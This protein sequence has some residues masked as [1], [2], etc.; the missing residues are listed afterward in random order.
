MWTTLLA[1]HDVQRHRTSKRELDEIRAVIEPHLGDAQIAGL[2]ADGR[3]PPP[4]NASLQTASMA[5]ACAGYRV[6]A[7]AGHHRVTIDAITL[8]VGHSGQRYAER[9]NE[10]SRF[11]PSIAPTDAGRAVR[12][13]G[14]LLFRF[15]LRIG[16]VLV[17]AC[18]V[19]R[20][21]FF[22]GFLQRAE[23]L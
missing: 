7:K 8:A 17:G 23:G 22:I 11:V 6:T 18:S 5:I 9:P 2:S 10:S 16:L 4:Y 14:L 3:S 15:F 12:S 19:S 13:S 21:F 20:G 1:S